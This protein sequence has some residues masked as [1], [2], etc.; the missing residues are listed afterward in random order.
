MQDAV[1]EHR[2]SS[3]LIECGDLPAAPPIGQQ[4]MIFVSFSMQ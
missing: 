2:F 1:Y 4:R 3:V